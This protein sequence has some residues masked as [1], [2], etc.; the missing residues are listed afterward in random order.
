MRHIKTLDEALEIM[1]LAER[2]KSCAITDPNQPDNPIVYVTPEFETHTG[3]RR[4]EVLGRNC[5][6]LQ[7]VDTDPITVGKIRNAI[8]RMLPIEVEILNYRKNGA[9]F[10]NNLSLR[11]VFSEVGKLTSFVAA[12]TIREIG[13]PLDSA[14][15]ATTQ[16]GGTL[17]LHSHGLRQHGLN[18]LTRPRHRNRSSH[19]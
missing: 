18:R 5:R 1:T 11:P 3:Y 15:P 9:P 8:D 6:F 17:I 16:I 4:E 12:Q 10:W 2:Q 7:G 19:P 13:E 14:D